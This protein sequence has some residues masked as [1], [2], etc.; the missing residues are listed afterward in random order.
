MFLPASPPHWK[1]LQASRASGRAHRE[2]T[3]CTARGNQPQ[4]HE[5]LCLLILAGD[6]RKMSGTGRFA[7]T[8][9]GPCQVINYKWTVAATEAHQRQG[10]RGTNKSN[11]P[12]FELG[13]TRPE[14]GVEGGV[15]I[16]AVGSVVGTPAWFDHLSSNLVVDGSKIASERIMLALPSQEVSRASILGRNV[17]GCPGR[18][19]LVGLV[20]PPGGSSFHNNWPILQPPQAL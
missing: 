10:N 4:I 9:Q 5:G 15:S 20:R 14:S 12:S 11:R 8:L 1:P 17:H 18:D 7:G 13:D 6:G 16:S 3:Y 19:S 2:P